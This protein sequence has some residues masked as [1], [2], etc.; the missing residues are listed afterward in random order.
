M[1]C[2]PL[3]RACAVCSRCVGAACRPRT[4]PLRFNAALAAALSATRSVPHVGAA[5]QG[6]APRCCG[7][8]LCTPWMRA[9]VAIF[10]V[11]CW[12]CAVR[13]VAVC[14]CGSL[15]FLALL[16]RLAAVCQRRFSLLWWVGRCVLHELS[17]TRY[18]SYGPLRGRVL[19]PRSLSPRVD[20]VLFR[21]VAACPCD[22]L[23]YCA[24]MSRMLRRCTSL[25]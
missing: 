3:P 12:C 11:A 18:S 14:Q 10:A 20:V 16:P 6:G 24:S 25:S 21:S 5:C 9:V 8:V 2:S 4:S 19:V 1:V 23:L 22:A 15:R 7:W 17:P 13:L